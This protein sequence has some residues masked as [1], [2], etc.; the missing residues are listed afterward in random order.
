MRKRVPMFKSDKKPHTFKKMQNQSIGLANNSPGLTKSESTGSNKGSLQNW[1]N[2]KKEARSL[3]IVMPVLDQ[4]E[5]NSMKSS[6]CIMK[7]LI[8]NISNF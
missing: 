4:N 7:K 3:R 8:H 6:Q 2:P 1:S 5:I